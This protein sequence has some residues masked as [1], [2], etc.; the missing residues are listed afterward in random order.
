MFTW[1]K[2][3]SLFNKMQRL[4][5]EMCLHWKIFGNLYPCDKGAK[6]PIIWLINIKAMV[7]ISK[8]ILLIQQKSVHECERY[9]CSKVILTLHAKP[10]FLDNG[11]FVTFPQ[12][13]RHSWSSYWKFYHLGY[14]RSFGPPFVGVDI[15]VGHLLVE[16]LLEV[17]AWG[18]VA[19]VVTFDLSIQTLSFFLATSGTTRTARV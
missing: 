9:N 11:S 14:V 17:P 8:V 7:L 4:R 18:L 6:W 5:R 1:R 16:V 12:I 2:F 10:I 13:S 3:Q 15:V 19:M